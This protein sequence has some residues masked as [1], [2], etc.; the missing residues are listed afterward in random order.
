MKKEL[1]HNGAFICVLAVL[2]SIAIMGCTDE[3]ET[4]MIPTAALPAAEGITTAWTDN[5]DENVV[6]IEAKNLISPD[7]T[8]DR[9]YYIAWAEDGD[10]V[11]RLGSLKLEGTTGRL[12]STTHLKDFDVIITAED[13]PYPNK[14]AASPILRSAGPVL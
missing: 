8:K 9:V 6:Q 1:L 10:D 5:V 2:S 7:E 3:K 14:P 11:S 4:R 12:I 13:E